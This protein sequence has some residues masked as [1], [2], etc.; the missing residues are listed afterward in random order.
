MTTKVRK[1]CSTAGRGLTRHA[2]GGFTRHTLGGFTLAEAMMATVVLGIAAAGVLL[3]FAGGAKVRAQGMRMTLA[4]K[5]ATDLMERIVNTPF[6][7]IA[8]AYDGYS[9]PQGQVKDSVGSVFTDP[10]YANFSRAAS[11]DYVYVPQQSGAG[12]PSF[13]RLTVRVKYNGR[14]MAVIERLISK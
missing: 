9:E 3:P 10:A 2:F 4:A 5:L 11:C 6:E 1:Q 7:Q 14:E 13:I 12:Q 8:T